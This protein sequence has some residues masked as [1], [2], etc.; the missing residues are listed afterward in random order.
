MKFCEYKTWKKS[1][2]Y[3]LEKCGA[4]ATA[5]VVDAEGMVHVRLCGL[6][7]KAVNEFLEGD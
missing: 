6:H 5:K 7:G 4:P 3:K 2:N 1:S